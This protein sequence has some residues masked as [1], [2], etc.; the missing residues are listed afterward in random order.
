MTSWG[1]RGGEPDGFLSLAR[2]SAW[3]DVNRG[4]LKLKT[5]ASQ[6]EARLLSARLRAKMRRELLKVSRRASEFRCPHRP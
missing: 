4:S 1:K 5:N 2:V 3:P 6:G